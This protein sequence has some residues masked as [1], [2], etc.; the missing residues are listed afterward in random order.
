MGEVDNPFTSI[1]ISWFCQH[2]GKTFAERKA[3]G[4]LPLGFI[5]GPFTWAVV[6]AL[7]ASCLSEFPGYFETGALAEFRRGGDAECLA[8]LRAQFLYESTA[9]NL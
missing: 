4:R 7:C 2:C 9:M 8:N 1:S 3:P 5:Y 6:N